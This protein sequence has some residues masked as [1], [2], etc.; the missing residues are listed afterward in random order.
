MRGRGEEGERKGRGRGEKGERKG[1]GYGCRHGVNPDHTATRAQI[2]V[3]VSVQS[4][5]RVQGPRHS[6]RS[7]G[8][9]LVVGIAECTA[10]RPRSSRRRQHRRGH[11]PRAADR[12]LDRRERFVDRYG[13]SGWGVGRLGDVVLIG[14]Y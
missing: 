13:H 8:T 4:E 3:H 6:W 12:V 9:S 14:L 1:R 10:R 11:L 2:S 7:W 5:M